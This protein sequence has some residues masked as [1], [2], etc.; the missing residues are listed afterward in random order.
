M[1][2]QLGVMLLGTQVKNCLIGGPAFGHLQKGDLIVKID[3]NEVNDDNILPFLLGSDIPGSQVIITVQRRKEGTMGNIGSEL[4]GYHNLFAG[5]DKVDV[6]LTRI[7]T[8]EIADRRRMFDLFTF[9]EVV[10]VKY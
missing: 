2:V 7:S 5:S 4:Y 1:T 9:L 6:V 3:G 8:A 10:P